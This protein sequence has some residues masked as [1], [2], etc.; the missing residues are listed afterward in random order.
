MK[1][2]SWKV[3]SY[4]IRPAG[5]P[6]RCFYC[7]AILGD[8]HNKGC[9]LRSKTVIV[10]VE[11]EIVHVVPEDWDAKQIEFVINDSSSCANNILDEIEDQAERLGCLCGVLKGRFVR[12]AT[13]ED[14]EKFGLY[15][16]EQNIDD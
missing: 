15:I 16:A 5:K 14:E 6:D 3:D 11:V 12:E 7:D 2:N 9:V 10:K 4:A 13:K 8:E 1:L